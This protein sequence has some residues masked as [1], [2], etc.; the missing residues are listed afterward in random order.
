MKKV[1][2][3]QAAIVVKSGISNLMR[4]L[5]DKKIPDKANPVKNDIDY[6]KQVANLYSYKVDFAKDA[7]GKLVTMS[8]KF[9][10]DANVDDVAD[11]CKKNWPGLAKKI[12]A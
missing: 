7:Y 10:K 1:T 8:D 12:L 4:D 9:A 2:P 6:C 11:A 3:K 5:A